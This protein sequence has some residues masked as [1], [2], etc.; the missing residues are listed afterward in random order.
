MG[1]GWDF[2]DYTQTKKKRSEGVGGVG[3]M[4]DFSTYP[5]L[6]GCFIVMSVDLT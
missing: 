4:K 3:G 2:P 6:H 1:I 5:V